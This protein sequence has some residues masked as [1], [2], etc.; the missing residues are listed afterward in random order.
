MP[1]MDEATGGARV[2]RTG[3]AGP[4]GLFARRS[5]AIALV[6]ALIGAVLVVVAVGWALSAGARSG[7]GITP[8]SP[9]RAG[10]STGSSPVDF[11]DLRLWLPPGWKLADNIS[12]PC[13]TNPVA[14]F[15]HAVIST[16]GVDLSC[17]AA[18][19]GTWASVQRWSAAPPRTARVETVNGLR[20]WV[21]ATGP[22]GAVLYDVRRYSESVTTYGP[23]SATL[24]RSVG[25]SALDAVLA[26]RERARAP[27]TWRTVSLNGVSAQVPPRWPVRSHLTGLVDIGNCGGSFPAP[28]VA[29]VG[30]KDLFA[31]C[32][33]LSAAMAATPRDGLWLVAG[34]DLPPVTGGPTWPVP[35]GTVTLSP[36]PVM[37][38]DLV[39]ALVRAH[40]RQVLATVGLGADPSVAEEILG[41]LTASARG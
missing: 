27:S 3:Q 13:S 23:G 2:G 41:S 38:S 11:W 5:S 30:G 32:P 39:R 25:P 12:S 22:A 4:K 1:A 17:S 6:G 14:T 29:Y 33:C 37:G 28:P 21:W 7:P 19:R 26:T 35:G 16:G 34:P 24:A 31:F 18:R 8:A 9:P 36:P 40:G 20:V 10:A 15:D